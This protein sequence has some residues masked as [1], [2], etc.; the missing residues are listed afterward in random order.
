MSI[1]ISYLFRSQTDRSSRLH[2]FSICTGPTIFTIFTKFTIFTFIYQEQTFP[3][4]IWLRQEV[5]EKVDILQKRS[6]NKLSTQYPSKNT[7]IE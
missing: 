7:M 5:F 3:R 6:P 4:E 1:S 2:W